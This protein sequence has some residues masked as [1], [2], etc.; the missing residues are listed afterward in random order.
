M[1]F[2]WLFAIHLAIYNQRSAIAGELWL[3]FFH[4]HVSFQIFYSIT[5]MPTEQMKTQLGVNDNAIVWT[6]NIFTGSQV[7][8]FLVFG[9]LGDRISR[10]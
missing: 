5:E 2:F 10:R 9:C 6:E 7:I 8:F 3:Y 4:R 1:L